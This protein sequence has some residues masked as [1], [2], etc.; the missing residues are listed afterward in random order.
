MNHVWGPAL[1]SVPTNLENHMSTRT[2]SDYF[3]AMTAAVFQSGL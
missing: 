3:E 2:L 1:S